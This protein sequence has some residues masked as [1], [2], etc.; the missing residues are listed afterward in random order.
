MS[1]LYCLSLSRWH[2]VAE[3][4]SR[5]YSETVAALRSTISSTHVSAYLGEDQEDFLREQSRSSLENLAYAFRIQ[6]AVATIRQYVGDAN[7]H[8]NVSRKL[9]E[10]D[11]LNRRI[12]VLTD[13][14]EAQSNE[15]VTP[16]QL[17][18]LPR[19]YV[20][21]GSNYDSRRPKIRVRMLE[22]RD[23]EQLQDQ[24]DAAKARSYALADEIA[25][26]NRAQVSIELESE[27]AI[28]AGL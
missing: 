2:K 11:K 18:N 22:V 10:F 13:L 16:S 8:A 26:L 3:R 21:D 6:D 25:D 14:L 17:R 5:D 20:A 23:I 4:L 19:D 9:A 1:Q 24:L 12:K 7:V 15:M 28:V 27:V